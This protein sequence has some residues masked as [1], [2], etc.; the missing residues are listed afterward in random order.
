LLDGGVILYE[1]DDFIV[2]LIHCLIIYVSGNGK[3]IKPEVIIIWTLNG[4]L[5]LFE[6]LVV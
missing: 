2:W 1:K 5:I 6:T 4:T 3:E